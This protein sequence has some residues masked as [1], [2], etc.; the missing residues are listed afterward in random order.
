MPRTRSTLQEKVDRINNRAHLN[1]EL[2]KACGS[3]RV[4]STDEKGNMVRYISS[5]YPLGAMFLWLEGFEDALELME[6]KR[7]RDGREECV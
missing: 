1:L 5:R 7:K 6:D 2:D 3:Y 4:G